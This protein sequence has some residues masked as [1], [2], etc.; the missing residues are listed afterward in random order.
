M[1]TLT[2]TRHALTSHIPIL[3]IGNIP[4]IAP[5]C[6]ACQALPTCFSGA[7]ANLE[8]GMFERIVSGRRRI[9]RHGSLFKPDDRLDMFY[10]VRFGQFKMYA[11]DPMGQQ[12]LIGFHM[13]GDLIG[14]DAIATGK[15]QFRAVA[16]EDSEVC[17]ISYAALEAAMTSATELQRKFIQMISQSVVGAVPATT[18]MPTMRCDQRFAHFLLD[19]AARYAALGYS[20]KS[21][22]LSMSRGDISCYLGIT[23]ESVSR[24]IARFKRNGWIRVNHRY[25]DITDRAGLETLLFPGSEATNA[26]V[27]RSA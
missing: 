6:A 3:D 5:G 17:E 25:V 22:R 16:L 8:Q 10:A 2:P 11:T 23:A 1:T 20:G 27:R 26:D 24:L 9:R 12:R 15:H 7:F 18:F 13:P 21:F 19:L 4:A 14:L